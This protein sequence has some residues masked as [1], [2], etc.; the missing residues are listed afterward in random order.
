MLRGKATQRE[1]ASAIGISERTY[2]RYE[3]GERLPNF[4]TA[5]RI[6]VL[7]EVELNWILRGGREGKK[8]SEREIKGIQKV[9]DEAQNRFSNWT[10]GNL[11]EEHR[12]FRIEKEILKSKLG[13]PPKKR[14]DPRLPLATDMLKEIFSHGAE[15]LINQI[16]ESLELYST[17]ASFGISLKTLKKL[18]KSEGRK[19]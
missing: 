8:L 15:D 11:V 19:K 3:L 10:A 13:T 6:S 14:R 12:R 18:A 1:F 5:S 16:M 2:Q 7:C 17:L 4:L 9:F